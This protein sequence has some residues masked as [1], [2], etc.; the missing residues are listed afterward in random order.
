MLQVLE[1]YL[2]LAL[3]YVNSGYFGLFGAPVNAFQGSCMYVRQ[4]KIVTMKLWKPDGFYTEVAEALV[5]VALMRNITTTKLSNLHDLGRS[6]SMLWTWTGFSGWGPS[7]EFCWHVAVVSKFRDPI[8][9]DKH[10]KGMGSERFPFIMRLLV[11]LAE[12]Q[13]AD[14]SWFPNQP[15]SSTP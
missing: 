1:G 13:Q 4:I 11:E 7:C 2:L 10:Q 9:R 5:K 14:T 3:K 6:G 12:Y 15:L 8:C